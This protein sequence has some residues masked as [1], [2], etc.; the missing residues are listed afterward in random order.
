VSADAEV[1]RQPVY[2]ASGYKPFCEMTHADVAARAAELSA[3]A[4]TAAL[5]RVGSVARAWG[6]LERALAAAGASTVGELDAEVA[7]ELGR[8]AW[9]VA[10]RLL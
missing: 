4:R 10:P 7:V 1:L 6:E 9:V 3:T 2:T 5:A 8:K